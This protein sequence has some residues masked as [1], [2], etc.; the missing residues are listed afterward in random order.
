MSKHPADE[1]GS[2][3]LGEHDAALLSLHALADDPSRDPGLIP[4][5]RR[6]PTG[7]ALQ[8]LAEAPVEEV[9]VSARVALLGD[10]ARAGFPHHEHAE[11]GYLALAGSVAGARDGVGA[12]ELL[13]DLEQ[14]ASEGVPFSRLRSGQALPH[15][16]AAFVGQDVCSVR[17]VRTDGLLATWVYSEFETD[18]PFARVAA[19][20]DPHYWPARGPMLFK[21]MDLVG[22]DRPVGLPPPG[23]VHWHGIF[24]EEVQL[25]RRVNTLL[26]CDYWQDGSRAA[27]MTYD[28]ALSLD[29]QID[30]DRGFLLV[31]DVGPVRRVK[32]LKIVGF[33]ED[34]WDA[35]VPL[36]RPYWTDW[37]RAAVEGGT[38]STATPGGAP[39]DPADPGAAPGQPPQPGTRSCAWLEPAEEWIDFMGE[40]ARTYVT[41]VDDMTADVL[42]PDA[43][44]A[45]VA[46]HQQRIFSQMAKDWSQAWVS[47]LEA[48]TTMAQDGLVPGV[49]RPS[50][51]GA[52]TGSAGV[53]FTGRAPAAAGQDT[54]GTVWPV[55]DLAEG[56]VPTVSDLVAIESGGARIPA[57]SIA[58]SVAPLGAQGHGVRLAVGASGW[59]PGLYVGELTPRPGA[60]PVP[61]Q[62]YISR[63]TEA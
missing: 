39:V 13:D 45:D 46:Q 32:A 11:A 37:V 16:E 26:H 18:A 19:W 42:A 10:L 50:R 59:A 6:V 51:G 3:V 31:N 4:G 12:Q 36:V 5:F 24:H 7:V 15:H 40:S 58:T 9:P 43:G 41:L 28:L 17:T 60:T 56:D 53:R 29:D 20:V 23:D 35:L 47:G 34:R 55:V 61:V 25:V 21:A 30:V 44:P 57:A 27:G 48:V 49:G 1:P 54:E 22:A 38:D 62:L 52:S 63:A 8:H 33:K 14:A 2:A